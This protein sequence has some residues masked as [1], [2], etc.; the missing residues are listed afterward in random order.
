MGVSTISGIIKETVNDIWMVL[1][2]LHMP[3]PDAQ[4]FIEIAN[5]FYEKRNFPHTIGAIDCMHVRIKRPP[6][7][8]SKYYNY[9]KYF[10]IKLQAVAAGDY[11]F[12]A[13]DVGGF[14]SENDAGTF[15]AS[16]FCKALEKDSRRY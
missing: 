15:K 3:V 10:S 11:K 16:S 6:H 9:K 8:V 14:G 13:I 7:T 2:P 5:D 1:S 12:I 4:Y